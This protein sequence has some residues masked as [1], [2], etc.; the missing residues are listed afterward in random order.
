MSD[1]SEH[2]KLVEEEW[3]AYLTTGNDS[4]EAR[5]RHLRGLLPSDPRCR[6]CNAPFRGIGGAVMKMISD[7]RPSRLNPKICNACE[8]FANQHQGGAE[9]EMSLLFADVRGSTTIAEGMSPSE[10]GKLI[11]RFYNAVTNVLIRSDAMIDKLIGDQAA[12]IYVPGFAGSDHAARAVAAAKAVLRVTGH[13]D[14]GGPWIPLGV[15]VH[16]GVAFF[17]AVGSED[18]TSDITVLGDAPNT[19]ARLSSS[20]EAGEILVS[21]ATSTAAEMHV[22]NREKRVLD[23][24]GKSEPVTTHVLSDY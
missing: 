3:R 17:G 16:T 21:E 18:G 14:T 11:N 7:K 6:F 2:D 9:V 19:A 20:A 1:R 13:K 12:G 8:T 23:L 15:G 4:K 5:Y 24:K 10:F 22:D